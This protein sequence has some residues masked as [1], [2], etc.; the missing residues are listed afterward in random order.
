[1]TLGVALLGIAL[2]E[3]MAAIPDHHGAAA[4]FSF[5]DDSLKVPVVDG[6]VFHLDGE[7]L[8]TRIETGAARDSPALEHAVEFQPE[9]VMQAARRMFLYYETKS[10]SRLQPRLAARFGRL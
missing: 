7:P 9:V 3:P 1:M 8:L 5:W 4:I 2:G 6:V 10:F